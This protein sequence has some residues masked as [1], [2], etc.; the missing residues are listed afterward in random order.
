MGNISISSVLWQS[1][2]RLGS[3]FFFNV[4]QNS[5]V[6]TSGPREIIMGRYIIMNSTCLTQVLYFFLSPFWHVFSF[7]VFC[8]YIGLHKMWQLTSSKVWDKDREGKREESWGGH[9]FGLIAVW[10]NM[11]LLLHILLVV[12]TNS[13]RI[14]EGPGRGCG[15]KEV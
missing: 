4:W 1:F 6:E 8:V 10:S 15:Y 12:Q 9:T 14:R 13:G 11:L 2:Y 7:I 5:P 3:I